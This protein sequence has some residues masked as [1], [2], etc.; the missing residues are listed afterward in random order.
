MP[1]S[2]TGGPIPTVAE[3]IGKAVDSLADK[4]LGYRI[5]IFIARICFRGIYFP[6]MGRLAWARVITQN[7]RT[8]FKLVKEGFGAWYRLRLKSGETFDAG[9]EV[10]Q[11]N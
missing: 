2:S 5:N 10:I 1:R 8:I 3:A 7:R 9:P 4:S 6:Q 11:P